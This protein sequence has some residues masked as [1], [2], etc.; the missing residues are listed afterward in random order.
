MSRTEFSYHESPEF[1][2]SLTQSYIS[3]S[4]SHYP[5]PP[6]K[7]PLLEYTRSKLDLTI[8][9]TLNM[10]KCAL[11]TLKPLEKPC[12]SFSTTKLERFSRVKLFKVARSRC[13]NIVIGGLVYLSYETR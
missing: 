11:K 9:R 2:P 13:I 1:L 10:A 6:G 12:C 8:V 4:I 7:S 5:I 3:T